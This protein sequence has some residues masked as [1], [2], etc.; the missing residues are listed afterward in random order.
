MIVI[1]D[2]NFQPKPL[3]HLPV[4]DAV[5]SVWELMSSIPSLLR[6]HALRK[7]SNPSGGAVGIA[8]DAYTFKVQ[9]VEQALGALE[10]LFL[11]AVAPKVC[12]FICNFI[13][14]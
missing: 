10:E 14:K 2:N 12:F 5:R 1:Y 8:A 13:C 4:Q 6:T 3:K 7:S 9:R 11:P